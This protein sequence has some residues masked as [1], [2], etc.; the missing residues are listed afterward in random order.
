MI[1]KKK[2]WIKLG[3]LTGKRNA[4]NALADPYYFIFLLFVYQ[5]LS[6]FHL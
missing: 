4:R 2:G 1:K 3:A 5:I 6:I